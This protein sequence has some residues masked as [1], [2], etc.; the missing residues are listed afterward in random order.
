MFAEWYICRIYTVRG[1]I[2]MN[3]VTIEVVLNVLNSTEKLEITTEQLEENLSDLGMDS[4]TFIQI[5]VA[6]EEKFECE[7][8]DEKLLITEMDTVQKMIDVLQTLYD[9]Q[10]N[11]EY[12][13]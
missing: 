3:A 5:I 13:K 4:I 7:I 10:C 1:E 2:V 12:A 11:Y 8:P 6:L 9:D